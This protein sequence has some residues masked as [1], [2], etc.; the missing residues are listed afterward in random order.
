MVAR[1]A[2]DSDKTLT[3]DEWFELGCALEL[4]APE[5]SRD[6]YNRAIASDPQHADAHVNLG[7]LL[8]EARQPSLAEAHYRL[9]L[10]ARANHTTAWFNLGVS[11]EDLDRDD[12]AIEAYRNAAQA[13]PLCADAYYNLARLYERQGDSTQAL[14]Y[15]STYRR[16]LRQ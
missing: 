13:D 4:S 11:L 12:E 8:H 3:A 2:L 9:A 6:A 16:L 14:R 7:R 1:E 10:A 15:L 5:K